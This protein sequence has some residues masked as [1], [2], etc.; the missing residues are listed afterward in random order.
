MIAHGP[1]Q[2]CATKI[3]ANWVNNLLIIYLQTDLP[4]MFPERAQTALIDQQDLS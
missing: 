1:F 2:N 3:I 4:Q